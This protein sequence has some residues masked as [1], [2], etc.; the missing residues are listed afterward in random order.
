MVTAGRRELT[1]LRLSAQAIGGE[2]LL[3]SPGAVVHHLLALQAQ[4]YPGALWSIALRCGATLTDVERA[5]ADKQIVRSWP[6]RG[7]LH[8]VPAEDLAWMLRISASRQAT[9]SASRRSALGITDHDLDRAREIAT[10]LASGG[11]V[12]RDTLLAGFEAG[13]IST[14][15]QRGYH[16]IW[17]LA[18]DA[19]LVHGPVDGTQPT[20]ALL[21]EWVPSP[22]RLEGD[23]A[24]GEFAARYFAGHGPATERDFAW[25]ASLTLRDARTGI[26]I[27]AP[28]KREIDGVVYFSSPNVL[29]ARNAVHALPGFDE[30]ML[31]YQDRSAALPARFAN[32]IVPGNNGVFLPTIVTNGQVVGTW[33][34]TSRAKSTV[35]DVTAFEHLSASARGGVERAMQRYARFLNTEVVVRG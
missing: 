22:R 29:P 27:A 24:L 4:D 2:S 34:R 33:R 15:A 1:A 5:I 28:E 17:N 26:A 3:D 23:E 32:R 20:F 13:G 18:H 25:W 6:M 31:G 11:L 16:L 21:D 8:F 7:T 30:F 19:L 10:Q 9:W 35:I 14:Q 12:R